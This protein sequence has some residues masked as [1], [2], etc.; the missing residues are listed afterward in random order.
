MDPF[1]EG[2]HQ[3]A[4][5]GFGAG[6][7]FRVDVTIRSGSR[8]ETKQTQIVSHGFPKPKGNTLA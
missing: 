5:S 7:R 4:K 6:T 8:S 2:T 1:G 3:R